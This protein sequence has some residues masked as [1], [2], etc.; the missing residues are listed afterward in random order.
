[1]AH[2]S[3]SLAARGFFLPS[4]FRKGGFLQVRDGKFAG[5]SDEP[6]ADL[7]LI[8]RSDAYVAPGFVDTHIHGFANHDFMDADPKGN[9]EILAALAHKGTTSILATTLTATT[10]AID[11]ACAAVAKTVANRVQDSEQTR[12]QGIFLEGPF[13]TEK[14]K[15]AQNAA[16][17]CDPSLDKLKM[18]QNAAEGL[19]RKSALA[20]ERKGA[21]AYVRGA[22][23]MGVKVALGH[24]DASCAEG[25][26]AVDAGANTFVHVYNGMSGLH[27]RTPGLVACAM[28][29]NNTYAELIC[30][31]H[32]VTPEAIDA[33]VRA[34]GW[35]EVALISD[36][37]R[38]GGMP[39]GDYMLGELPIVLHGGVAYLRDAGNL[40]GSVLSLGEAVR[41]IVDWG[42]ESLEHAVAMASVVPA[43]SAGID[44]R[45]G[46]ILPG[47]DA[48]LVVLSDDLQVRETYIGGR[49][50]Q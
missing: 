8:D 1:M 15:G 31:G 47:R 46:Q 23:A 11:K 34:K 41:N 22:V 27:H 4:G 21:E 18:W 25:Y 36:C 35:D 16:Y 37:L 10:E 50:V 32:H 45:C 42:I 43:R 30:D 9:E 44:D 5:V 40:A 29:T 3:F 20:P 39:D 14:H 2:N 6:A 17:L 7:E 26:H 38:C 19:I 13:F 49:L 28:T 12:I 33:L 24:S 48:D